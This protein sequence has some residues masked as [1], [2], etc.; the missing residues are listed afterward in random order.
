MISPDTLLYI[1]EIR[2]EMKD[3]L[4][5]APPSYVGRWN[6]EEFSYLFFTAPEDDHVNLLMSAGDGLLSARHEMR[7]CDWQTG[8]PVGGLTVGPFVFV[9][10][11][12]PA[13]PPGS[14][15]LDPSV[16]FGDGSHPTTVS[17]L[18]L[19]EEIF[20]THSVA[21]MLDLGTGSG[22]LA[23]AAASV[24]VDRILAVDKNH[25]AILTARENVKM[26]SLTTQIKVVQGEARFFID[27]PFD[28]VTVNLPFGVLRELIPLK[29]VPLHKIWIV[30]GIDARQGEVLMDLFFDQGFQL[31]DRRAD[32]PWMTFM[33]INKCFD[34]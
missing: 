30:S 16:V 34:C 32:P 4:L 8:V 29:S 1:Y 12:H 13:P 15:L 14:L 9:T 33:A 17:C 23:L 24:G 19:M 18:Q 22:I 27:T 3:D 10:A 7:Y 26:N 11:D 6:E 2:G 25:L 31:L 20:R 21:S 28:L 5:A